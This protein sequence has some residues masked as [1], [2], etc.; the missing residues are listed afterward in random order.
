MLDRRG[1]RRGIAGKG[2]QGRNSAP[3]QSP[4]LGFAEVPLQRAPPHRTFAR[5]R[6][7]S[8]NVGVHASVESARMTLNLKESSAPMQWRGTDAGAA[9]LQSPLPRT[10]VNGVHANHVDVPLPLPL[11]AL[12]DGSAGV[13]AD[14]SFVDW[15][16]LFCAVKDRL[17]TIA[18]DRLDPAPLPHQMVSQIKFTVF[19]CVAAL[20]QLH[21]SLRHELGR[22]QKLALDFFDAQTALAQALTELSG[23]QAGERR[24]RHLA[25]HDGLTLLPNRSCFRERLDRALAQAGSQ[26]EGLAVLYL[27]LD[28]FK[29]V[30]DSHGHAVGDDLLKIVA[31]RLMRALRAEDVV[32][33]LG[34]DEF[35]CLLTDAIGRDQLRRVA[36]HLFDTVAAPVKIGHLKVSV[37]PSIGIAVCPDDGLTCEALLKSADTAMYR[38]KREQSGYSF[39]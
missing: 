21:T 34:G 17:K 22:Q 13:S 32:G 7:Q 4:A 24:A 26:R 10:T 12:T 18:L 35:A 36:C 2:C 28:G 27:D 16:D 8:Q 38:A 3:V 39:F 23:M 37:R 1:N 11:P 15:D 5:F 9:A 6:A 30:N 33:R 20:D 14:V 25:L 29:A 19:E 31:A